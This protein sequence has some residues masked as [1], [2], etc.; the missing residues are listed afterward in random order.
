M[1]KKVMAYCKRTVSCGA[2]FSTHVCFG[3]N[4]TQIVGGQ[5]ED[6]PGNLFR[7]INTE[8]VCKLYQYS[9]RNV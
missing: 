7:L 6:L 1:R 9:E 2:F 4:T 8:C 5:H 3:T